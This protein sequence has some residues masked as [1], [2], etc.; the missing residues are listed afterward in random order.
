MTTVI[1]TIVQNILGL[2]TIN[3]WQDKGRA[4]NLEIL[5][6]TLMDTVNYNRLKLLQLSIMS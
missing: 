2:I 3:N 6:T 5:Y 1:A 4:T